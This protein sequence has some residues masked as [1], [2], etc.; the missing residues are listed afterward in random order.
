[1]IIGIALAAVALADTSIAPTIEVN[2]ADITCIDRNSCEYATLASEYPDYHTLLNEISVSKPLIGCVVRHE[3]GGKN[4][5]DDGTILRG[6]AGEFGVSQFM[7]GT[8]YSFAKKM[9]FYN[10]DIENPTD[11]LIVTYWAFKNNLGHHWTTLKGCL[12]KDKTSLVDR[13]I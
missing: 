5:N 12:P 6:K 3:S 4:Y 7:Y 10:A 2:K 11:Q 13:E 8:F 9:N 1:M